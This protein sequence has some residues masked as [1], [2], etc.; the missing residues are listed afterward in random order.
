MAR[1]LLM[2]DDRIDGKELRLTHE[3]LGLMLGTQRP[4]VTIALQA[5][6]REGLISHK[7]GAITILD[8]QTLQKHSNGTYVRPDGKW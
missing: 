5:L 6:E 2:A 4:G 8:R 1:W 7:R 3:F